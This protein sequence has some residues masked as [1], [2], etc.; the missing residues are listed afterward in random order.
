[1]P[2][3]PNHGGLVRPSHNHLLGKPTMVVG[4]DLAAVA[5]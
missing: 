2:I 4:Y 3:L 1:M 5:G